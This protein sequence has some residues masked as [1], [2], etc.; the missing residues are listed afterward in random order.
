MNKLSPGRFCE[1]RSKIVVTI[2]TISNIMP[3]RAKN[4]PSGRFRPRMSII[5]IV[6]LLEIRRRNVPVS[7]SIFTEYQDTGENGDRGNTANTPRFQKTAII[8]GW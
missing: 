7:S 8:E 5:S 6:F 1:K 3:K 2:R 4:A